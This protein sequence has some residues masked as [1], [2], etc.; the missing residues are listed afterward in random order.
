MSLYF[1]L[2]KEKYPSIADRI[3]LNYTPQF[4]IEGRSRNPNNTDALS[5]RTADPLWMLGRQWQ[6]GEFKGEDN[7]SP[8]QVQSFYRKEKVEAYSKSKLANATLHKLDGFPL[9]AKIESISIRP[10]DLRSRVRIGQQYE[11]LIKQYLLQENQSENA[12][13]LIAD[14]RDAFPLQ[15]EVWKDQEEDIQNEAKIDTK[16][17]RFFKLMQGKVVGGQQLYEEI[18]STNQQYPKSSKYSPTHF[19]VLATP[20][21]Q[22]K[23]WYNNLFIQ[24]EEATEEAWNAHQLA[25]EFKVHH[26]ISE[27]TNS[28]FTIN[29]PDYQ[30]GHLD[31]YSFDNADV[32][33]NPKSNILASEKHFPVNVSFAS[34]PDKRL[35]SFEDSKIDLSLMDVSASDLLKLMILDFSLVSGSDW[36]TIPLEMELGEACWIDRIEVEDVFGVKTVV[37]NDSTK[38]AIL[39]NDALKIWDLFKIRD[40][41]ALS[42]RTEDELYRD[43]EHFLFLAPASTF[44]IESKPL[45]ELFFIRDEYSNMVWAI[46]KRIPNALGKVVE[47]FDLHLELHEFFQAPDTE[48]GTADSISQ[49]RLANT[50]PSNWIPYLP[51]YIKGDANDVELRRAYMLRNDNTLK[52][53]Q[54]LSFLA[55]EDI[56]RVREEAIPKAGV[57]VQITNQRIRWTDGKTHVWKGRKVLTGKGE[58]N[59]G[60]RFDYLE[61]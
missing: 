9:E 46:E 10:I 60:L 42:D 39:N 26:K 44:R 1:K 27:E 19:K 21:A 58:G 57:R 35:F 16:S 24:P 48:E 61:D 2:L 43:E 41:D 50:V 7:G 37:K 56:L 40:F 33:L 23:A 54:P 14:L 6:F 17:L 51:S 45:E 20:T 22:L 52:D 49:F 59:S 8:I 25:Y 29:A 32:T 4:R 12:E 15:R 47:G 3:A 38:G 28:G 53:I 36:Y 34:M 13:Q 11:R 5:M 55:K 18:I 31:W 30:S